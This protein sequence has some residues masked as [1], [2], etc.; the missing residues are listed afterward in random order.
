ME[1]KIIKSNVCF[2]DTAFSGT[3]EQPVDVDFT[4]PD[5]CPDISKIFKC[6]AAARIS[7]KS[8]NGKNI[9]VDGSVAVTVIYCDADG[10]ICSYEYQY[11]FSKSAETGEEISGGQLYCRAVCEYINCRAVTGRKVD[12]HGAVSI[13]LRDVRQKKM[14]IISDIDDRDIEQRH[15]AAPATVPMGSSEK[16]LTVEEVLNVGQGQPPIGRIIRYDAKPCVRENKIINDKVVVKGDMAVRVLYC[17]TDEGTLQSIKTTLPFSQ[18]MDVEG[19]NDSCSCETRCDIAF[20][21]IKPRS[22]DGE[23][24]SLSFTAKLLI[25]CNASCSNDIAIISDAFSRKH[26]ANIKSETVCF[27]KISDSINEVFHCKKTIE[28][29]EAVSS[30]TDLW[31]DMQS[32][33]TK[34]EN[35]NMLI[36]GTVLACII[37]CGTDGMPSYTE[38]AIDFEYKYAVKPGGDEQYCKPEVDILSCGYTMLSAESLELRVD[39]G[40]NAAVYDCRNIPIITDIDID[41]S[42]PSSQ[43]TN[44]AM[45]IYFTGENECVWDI[46]KHYNSGVDEIMKINGLES[47]C[48]PEGKM[49]LV[50]AV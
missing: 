37:A 49:I 7:A 50:P 47:E 28:L 19:V 24:V 21:E 8:L 40:I 18:I 41:E 38:K 4:L 36:N 5:F 42:R 2:N 22:G 23:Q 26:L 34:F 12:I 27:K 39:L 35:G 17:P 11:P 10:K 6:R 9:T 31:C 45:T 14:D 3:V 25:T 30:V 32:V 13:N 15:S 48:L 16:Y 43:P 1:E 46:A 33:S 29:N 44:C 20:L